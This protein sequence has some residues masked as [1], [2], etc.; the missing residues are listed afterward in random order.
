MM[1]MM[2]AD[3]G[4]TN[5]QGAVIATSPA[6]MPLHAMEM[7]GLPNLKYQNAMAAA[8]PAMAAR[9]VFTATTEMRRS[10]APS[11][12]PGLKPIQ[13]K[14]RMNVPVTTNGMLGA[15]NA[16]GFPS[17]PYF[18]SRGPRMMARAI[19]QKP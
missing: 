6:S 3:V 4:L 2:M 1:P 9:F 18:P 10:V 19:A 16:L 15:G 17:A 12:E 14:S 13:P 8:A 5:A 11:V 7:S